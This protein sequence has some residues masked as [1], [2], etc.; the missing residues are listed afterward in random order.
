MWI[1]S[2]ARCKALLKEF[3]LRCA[4]YVLLVVVLTIGISAE[5]PPTASNFP[6]DQQVIAFLTESI[7]WYRHRA[8]EER[9]ATEPADLVFLQD[10]RPIA[11]Q[12]VQLSFD[13]A[14]ADASLAAA[15]QA[16]NQK[17][18]AA[19]ASRFS[20]DLAHFVQLENNA[21]EASR[22]ASQEIETIKKRL[23]TAHG[24]ER[25]TLQAALDVTQR[26]LDLLQAGA[27]SLRELVEFVQATG[28][29]QTDL[30]SSIDDLARTV[31][32][33]ASP[34][35]A[36][37]QTQNSEV[38]SL[39]KPRDF[40]ILGLSSEVSALGRKVGILDD[41]IGRTEKL[42]EFA[43]ALRTPLLAYINKRFPTTADNYLQSSDLRVLQ[44]QKAE[45]DALIAVAKAL[46]P[47]MVALDKQNVLLYAYTSHLKTW[48]AAVANEYEKTW[49]NLILRLVGVAVVIAALLLIGA[50]ARSFT[51]RYVRDPQRRHI[52]RVIERVAP[53]FMIVLV[54][55]FSFTSDLTS[56]ATFFGLLTAGVA[57][58]LQSVILSALGYFLLVGRR[59][60]RVGDRVQIS[61][62]TGNVTD[63]GWLQFRIQEID[64]ETQQPTGHVVTFSNSFV[65]VSPATGLCKCNRED[66]K[67]AQLEVA[68][69]TSQL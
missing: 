3:K 60:I 6:S 15:F 25:R 32:E 16:G 67:S 46:A 13:F 54:A 47:A 8:I 26:R 4:C 69:K 30:A 27:A 33:V 31:P 62:V 35:A 41:E 63:I 52:F 57:I 21:D 61:G 55:A 23:A 50:A 37:S 29:R 10:N 40:G 45:L 53:W 43:D 51:D 17:A 66:L 24:A 5:V 48:R 7:D 42:R 11:A 19:I 58:A 34:T 36:R 20:T 12:V 39:A 44:Q 1:A 2:R 14:R 38:V 9:L 18:S 22:Q 64:T 65:F 28:G 59:G 56:L 68:G 49:R